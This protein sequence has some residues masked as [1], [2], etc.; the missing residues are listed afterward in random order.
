MN[1]KN[2]M[3]KKPIKKPFFEGYTKVDIPSHMVDS[4]YVKT[5]EKEVGLKIYFAT[6]Q[7]MS[8]GTETK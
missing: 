3:K 8:Y 6:G 5:D 2:N 4:I 7:I 1:P